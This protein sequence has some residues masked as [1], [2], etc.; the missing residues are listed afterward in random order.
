MLARYGIPM[1]EFAEYVETAIAGKKVSEVYENNLN[2][3]LVLRYDEPF[4]NNIDAIQNSYIDT[5][6]GG[7]IP[8]RFV[9]DVIS[10]S[11]P[12]TINRENVQRKLVVSANV[13]GR[14]VGSVVN[15]IKETINNQRCSS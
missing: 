3:P 1:N 8:F 10:F 11:G 12:N 6:D 15:E 4:R 7:K 9:A 14:D 5:Y 13:A 2:F